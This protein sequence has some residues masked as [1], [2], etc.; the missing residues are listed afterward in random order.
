MLRH[1]RTWSRRLPRILLLLKLQLTLLHLLQQ[2][3]RRLYSRLWLLNR[4]RSLLLL[5]FHLCFGCRLVRC[6][7]RIVVRR[8]RFRFL[9]RLQPGIGGHAPRLSLFG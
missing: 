4:L 9:C 3:L 2:F 1:A 8:L 6:V 5:L 7:V